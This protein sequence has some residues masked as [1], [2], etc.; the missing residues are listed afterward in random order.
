MPIT[1]F[2]TYSS[3]ISIVTAIFISLPWVMNYTHS[4]K[5][6]LKAIMGCVADQF[7]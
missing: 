5:H 2:Y 1:V 7:A 6:D 3:V 4:D